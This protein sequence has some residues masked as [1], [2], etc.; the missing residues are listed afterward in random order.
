MDQTSLEGGTSVIDLFN[1]GEHKNNLKTTTHS[2]SHI[3]FESINFENKE[4]NRICLWVLSIPSHD[5]GDENQNKILIMSNNKASDP[6]RLPIM[7]PFLSLQIKELTVFFF[8]KNKKKRKR[9]T[10][11][12]TLAQNVMKFVLKLRN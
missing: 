4:C 1:K 9:K 11:L 7:V 8:P 5:I 12:N 3:P 10:Y 2:A 6:T